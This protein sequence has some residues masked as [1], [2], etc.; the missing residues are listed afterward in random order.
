MLVAILDATLTRRLRGLEEV[1]RALKS[2]YRW[3]LIPTA[4]AREVG[5]ESMGE[6][7]TER[8]WE[9][10]R[11]FDE[12]LLRVLTLSLDAGEAE[13]IAQALDVSRLPHVS[14]VDVIIDEHAGFRRAVE[15]MVGETSVRVIRTGRLLLM[16]KEGGLLDRVA[17]HLD[18]LT[19][20]GF[21]LAAPVRQAL[22]RDA[23]EA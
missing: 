21:W 1:H 12:H 7:L 3:V 15:T 23:G 4:V 5:M 16:L 17:P 18:A 8:S 6:L 13:T 9:L 11:R 14:G 22:L 19:A 10:C 20:Q 2:F